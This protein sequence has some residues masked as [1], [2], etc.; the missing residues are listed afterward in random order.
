MANQNVKMN[1]LKR[2]FQMLAG[3][4]PYREICDQHKAV[5]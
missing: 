3:N 2:A 1:K 5:L 4:I